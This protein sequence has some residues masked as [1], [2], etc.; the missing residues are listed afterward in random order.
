MYMLVAH[1]G[2]GGRFAFCSFTALWENRCSN[3]KNVLPRAPNLSQGL[4]VWKLQKTIQHN[5]LG[6]KT[7]LQDSLEGPV[8]NK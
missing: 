4:I 8:S 2:M 7:F 3:P 5:F 1:Q 6:D